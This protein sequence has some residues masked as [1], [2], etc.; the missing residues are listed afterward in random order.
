MLRRVFSSLALLVAS[1][2]LIVL[3]DE[4]PGWVGWQ[5]ALITPVV[6]YAGWQAMRELI[7]W[8]RQEGG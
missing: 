6:I 5:E 7:Q 2:V 1:W 4:T 8:Y 3:T